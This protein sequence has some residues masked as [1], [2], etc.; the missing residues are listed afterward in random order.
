MAGHIQGYRRVI[1]PLVLLLSLLSTLVLVTPTLAAPVI[2]LSPTSG[3][4]GTNILVEGKNFNSYIGDSIIITFGA[5]DIPGTPMVIPETGDFSIQFSVPE[6][7]TP[8]QYFV[9]VY[10]ITPVALLTRHAFDVTPLEISLDKTQGPV[11]TEVTI[12]GQGFYS[13]RLV[14]FYFYTI[15][16]EKIGDTRTDDVGNFSLSFIVPH[17]IA[18]QHAIV[19]RNDKG[20]EIQ[21]IFLVTPEIHSSINSAG[22]GQLVTLIGTGFGYRTDVEIQLGARPITTVRTSDKGDFEVVFNVPDVIPRTYD[23]KA[24]DVY[25][26]ES[27]VTFTVGA[28]VSIDQTSGFVGSGVTVTGD[29]FTASDEITIIFDDNT[30]VTVTADVFGEFS[31]S[32][33]IPGSLGG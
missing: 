7:T 1:L 25:E 19:A 10:T 20:N 29:G 5:S 15:S 27:S 21:T 30:V 6:G 4:V 32:F 31:A 9:S 13:D 26:N 17:S 18:G 28:T 23:L 12:T 3:A 24:E 8:G 11:D 14:D 16:A 2:I 33:A 22:P